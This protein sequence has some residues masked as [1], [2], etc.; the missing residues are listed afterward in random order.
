MNPMVLILKPGEVLFREGDECN[1]VYIVRQ[2]ELDVFREKDGSLVVL[3]TMRAGDV[4]GT[5]TIFTRETRTA[6][7]R[8][9][10]SAQ[11]VHVGVDT[12]EGAFKNL[13]V[14]VQA[15]L[16]DSV[17]RLKASN[18]QLLEAKINERKLQQK[19]GTTYHLASQFSALLAFAIRTGTLNNEGII[20]FPLLGFPER[21]ETILRRRA[22]D[23]EK[24]LEAFVKGS[25]VRVQVDKKWGRSILSPNAAIIEDF[26]NFVLQTSKS[27]LN[28]YVP[29]KYHLLMTSMVK[30]AQKPDAP[31][32]Y[33]KAD[34][35]E[36]L[37]K[38]S[39]K[40]NPN[41]VLND[42]LRLKIISSSNG[43]E[44]FSWSPQHVHKRLV[45]ESTVRFIKELLGAD[46]DHRAA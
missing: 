36:L 6:S 13:P 28:G 1:G 9:Q 25:L 23:F 46:S 8:A 38:R 27:E 45:F 17:A 12:I 33:S 18:D 19:V 14:W 44:K 35:L 42:L 29:I 7:A 3:A 24:M 40:P 21:C 5:S 34:I 30:I 2:G 32:F 43:G 4:I 11:V 20:L 41:E 16:K 22:D 31:Q 26:G 10:T 37:A 15:V 39:G